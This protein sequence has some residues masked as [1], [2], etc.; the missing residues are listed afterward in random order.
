MLDTQTAL[1]NY[2]LRTRDVL[3]PRLLF[4]ESMSLH[5]ATSVSHVTHSR[6]GQAST[7]LPVI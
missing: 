5:L 1:M 7:F 4:F 3:L 6:K 2:L